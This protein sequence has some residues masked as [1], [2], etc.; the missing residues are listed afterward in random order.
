MIE[1]R[2]RDELPNVGLVH[3]DLSE[4]VVADGIAESTIANT[5]DHG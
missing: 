4:I 2:K 5:S 1:T 3:M